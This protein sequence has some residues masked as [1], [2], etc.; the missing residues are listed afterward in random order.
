MKKGIRVKFSN[1]KL[2]R[3]YIVTSLVLIFVIC[4]LILS[5][6]QFMLIEW[7]KVTL[8]NMKDTI[9]DR[10]DGHRLFV[11]TVISF[12]ISGGLTALLYSLRK[13]K[14]IQLKHRQA[15]ARMIIENKW[16]ESHTEQKNSFFKDLGQ[17]KKEKIDY[18]PKIWY[19]FKNNN[20]HIIV[21]V[22][23]GKFQDH[24]L[25]LEERIE[26][27]LFCELVSKTVDDPH[28]N[29]TFSRN[30]EHLRIGIDDVTISNGSIKLMKG[31]AWEYDEFPHILVS[32]GIGSGKSYF[33]LILIKS[34]LEMNANVYIL[35]PKNSSLAD[36]MK[37]LD[38]VHYQ[39]EAIIKCVQDFCKNMVE[40][41]RIMRDMDDYTMGSN[42][43][44][45][46][47]KPNFLVFDEYVA[48]VD[49]LNKQNKEIVLKCLNQ[50]ALLGRE[51]GFFLVLGCQRPDSK[52]F[53][54]GMRDQFYFRLALGKMS[55]EGY[56]MM[57]GST[58]KV[59]F[60][61]NI[62]GR[63]YVDRGAG[64]I[65]EFY[66]PYVPSNYN[67][68]EVMQEINLKRSFKND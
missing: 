40:R 35:D 55:D 10:L 60:Q 2:I 14:K 27:G 39:Q 56:R 29:Y 30:L 4:F 18:F 51:S 68:I 3:N 46:G 61:K 52:F 12:L 11:N 21:A 34:F 49:S 8:S 33:L 26:S 67:F 43:T 17:R 13:S 63:G 16:Y 25:N 28:I 22:T 9:F 53:G 6:N 23:M 48:F 15:I 20:I 62:K 58:N 24:I 50:I 7:S 1:K 42:Y 5:L 37:I 38:D 59:Y 32:G 57:F 66:A 47:L 54:D 41:C 31:Y 44:K 65:S 45:L 36:L 64:I 19:K